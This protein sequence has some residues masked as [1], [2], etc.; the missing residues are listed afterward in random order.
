V[1]LQEW[2]LAVGSWQAKLSR[3]DFREGLKVQ[4]ELK[5][6]VKVY[7]Q[8]HVSHPVVTNA[9]SGSSMLPRFATIVAKST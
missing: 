5:L 3:K 4:V 2:Q 8:Y 1:A 7:S 9:V 6:Q